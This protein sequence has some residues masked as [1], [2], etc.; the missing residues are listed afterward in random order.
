MQGI[1]IKYGTRMQNIMSERKPYRNFKKREPNLTMDQK[2]E[3]FV[4]RNSQNGYFTKVSTISHKFGVSEEMMW[5]AVGGLLSNGLF[6]SVH[7]EYTGEMK[8][9][10][11]GKTYSIIGLERK[12]KREK[13]RSANKNQSKVKSNHGNTDHSKSDHSNTDHGKSDHSKSDHGKTDH[14]KSDHGKSD[15]SNTDH[16][17]TDHSNSNHSKTDHSKS[18]HSKTD[19][20]KSDHN[21]TNHSKTDHNNTNHSKTN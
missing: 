10:E 1:E 18:D 4:S 6:E 11:Y 9:C 19:H 13:Y 8:L 12:R 20:S 17:K 16:G 5:S 2:I 21:N 15:H 3:K 7:D 14:S